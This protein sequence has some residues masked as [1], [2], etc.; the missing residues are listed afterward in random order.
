MYS[1]ACSRH[2]TFL[3]FQI[4]IEIL[5]HIFPFLFD[6]TLGSYKFVDCLCLCAQVCRVTHIYWA[7]KTQIPVFKCLTSSVSG[8]SI[9]LL[10]VQVPCGVTYPVVSCWTWTHYYVTSEWLFLASLEIWT[11]YMLEYHGLHVLGASCGNISP[12]DAASSALPVFDVLH[13]KGKTNW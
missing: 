12:F 5:L 11:L 2:V 7:G 13:L 4:F 1:D 8:C 10:G 6:H 3:L 9:S